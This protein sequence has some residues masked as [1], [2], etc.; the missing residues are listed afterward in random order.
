MSFEGGF[1]FKD[2]SSLGRS[3]KKMLIVDNLKK[4]FR[5]HLDNGIEIRTWKGN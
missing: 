1:G 2:L 5:K 3:L 4:N